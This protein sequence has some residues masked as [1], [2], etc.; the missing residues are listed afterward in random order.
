MQ[1]HVDRYRNIHNVIL[2]V[3]PPACQVKVACLESGGGA[4]GDRGWSIGKKWQIFEIAINRFDYIVFLTSW[5][6]HLI[7]M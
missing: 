7:E 6:G 1:M 4:G 3:I 2:R 5:C